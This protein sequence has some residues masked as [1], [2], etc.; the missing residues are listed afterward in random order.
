MEKKKKKKKFARYELFFNIEFHDCCSHSPSVVF[1]P[2]AFQ[3]NTAEDWEALNGCN[4]FLDYSSQSIVHETK[5]Q[6]RGSKKAGEFDWLSK[7][8]R[9]REIHRLCLSF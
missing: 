7:A 4:Q 1:I 9:F 8:L 2:V 6:C 3:I 5:S